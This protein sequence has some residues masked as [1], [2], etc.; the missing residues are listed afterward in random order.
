M[1]KVEEIIKLKQE[2]G[3]TDKANEEWKKHF[4]TKS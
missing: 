4:H 3:R 2:L 1:K